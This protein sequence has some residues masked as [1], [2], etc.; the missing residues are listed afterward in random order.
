VSLRLAYMT[1]QYPRVTDTFIQREVAMLRELGHHVVTFSVRK[2]PEDQ[3]VGAETEAE[4]KTTIYL[5]PPRG[6]FSAHLDLLLRSPKNYFLAFALA[7]KT[8]P[9]GFRAIAL[10]IAYFAEAAMVARLMK[11]DSL[12]HL[13]NHLADSSC[14]VAA[15]ASQMGGFTFSFTTHIELND[16]PKR[17]WVGEKIRRAL[18]VNCISYFGRGQMMYLSSPEFWSKLRVVHCGVAP[19]VFE[20]KKHVGRG[21]HVLFVGRLAP[22]KGL[23]ILLDA[24]A[25]LEDV[26]LTIAGDGPEREFLQHEARRLDINE[27]VVFLG[28]QSQEQ[29]RALLRRVDVFAMTSLVEGIPVVLMEAMAA[30]VPVVATNISGIPELVHDGQN[31]F[32]VP[33]SDATA[34]ALAIRRLIEAAD[35]RN[36]FALAGRKTIEEGFDLHAESR[37]LASILTAALAGGNKAVRPTRH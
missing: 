35:L 1:G 4:R 24:L 13:H 26:T 32:L 28:Y 36:Q 34:T 16:E 2:P 17:W 21:N 7:C 15:I 20:V 3:N 33:P 8:C 12:S 31:G 14:S 22:A 10:Q 37:W 27:R 29:V 23:P 11:R 6:L 25:Q 18:F 5:L 19:T 9:P 30:G